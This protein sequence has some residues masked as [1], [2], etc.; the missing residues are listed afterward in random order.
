MLCNNLFFKYRA[1]STWLRITPWGIRRLLNW[2]RTHYN[3][4]DVII[5]ENGWSDAIGY[6]DD[7]MRVYYLKYHINNVLKGLPSFFFLYLQKQCLDL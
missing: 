3:N 1:A 2:I 6:L 7:A 4:P 5:T